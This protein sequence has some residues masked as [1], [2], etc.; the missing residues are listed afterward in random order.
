[1]GGPMGRAGKFYRDNFMIKLSPGNDKILYKILY[2][3]LS[4][5][6]KIP[7]VFRDRAKTPGFKA[8]P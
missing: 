1:M 3:I 7:I 2:K 5:Y 8:F 4:D 6:R